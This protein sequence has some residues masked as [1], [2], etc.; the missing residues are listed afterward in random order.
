MDDLSAKGVLEIETILRNA[1]EV[2]RDIALLR[3][4]LNET[5]AAGDRLER[6]SRAV[7]AGLEKVGK[8]ATA[9]AAGLKTANAAWDKQDK[10]Y[11]DYLRHQERATSATA[12][13]AG[14][15]D[16]QTSSLIAQRYALYDVASTYGILSAALLASSGYALKVGADFESAFTDVE[17]T[18]EGSIDQIEGLRDALID[19]STQI[20][21]SFQELS[22]IASLGNQ[23]GIEAENIESFTGTIARFAAISGVSAEQVAESFGKLSNLTGLDPSQYEN[24]GS[25]IAFV[26]RSSAAT[27]ASILSTSKEIAALSTGAGFSAEAIVGLSGALAS[28]SIAPEKAR[29]A[30]S[31]YFSTLESSV[32]AGGESLANFATVV[33][34]TSEEL[35]RMVRNGQGQ[36]VFQG[37][38]RGLSELDNVAKTT[39]LD[40]LGLSAVRVDQTF[41]ALSAN[42]TLVSE[43]FAQSSSAMGEGTELARQYA[44]VVDDLNSRWMMFVNSINA[45]VEAL[46][47]GAVTGLADLLGVMTEVVNA[48]R[49]FADN[50][51]ARHLATMAGILVTTVGLFFAYRAAVTLATAS[52]FALTTA[53]AGL[54]STGTVGGIRGLITAMLGLRSASAG[55]ATTTAAAATASATAGASANTASVGVN[56]LKTALLGLGKATIILALLQ[57]GVSLLTDFRGS[58]IAA[59]DGLYGF[60]SAAA[61]VSAAVRNLWQ[62]FANFLGPLGGLI[63]G[64]VDTAEGLDKNILNGI[65]GLQGWAQSLPTSETDGF[66]GAVDDLNFSTADAAGSLGDFSGGLDDAGGSAASAAEKVRTL[67]DYGNDLS[68]VFTRAFEIRFSGGQGLDAI[69]GGWNSI[70]QAIA[71][72]NQEIEDYRATMM[73]L[74]SDRAI[75]EY[76]LSVA[77]NYGDALRAGELRAELASID[78]DLKKTTADLT[79]AQDKNSK[80]LTGNTAGAIENR[81]EI[82]GLVTNYQSYIQALASSGLSQDQLK[83][84]TA[85]LKADFIAQ[86]TQLGYNEIELQQYAAAFDDVTLA[87]NRVPKN[88]TVTAN[89]DPAMQAL[90]EYEARLRQIGSTN[91]GGGSI[92]AP[93][94]GNAAEIIEA[95]AKIDY[96]AAAMNHFST[97]RPVPMSALDNTNSNL[98]A[99]KARLIALRGYAT[100]GYTGDGGKYEPKGIVH[101]GEFVFSKKATQNIGVANLAYAHNMAKRGY[102]DGGAVAP[103][104]ASS[105]GGIMQLSPVDRQLL[106]DVK[107]A[108]DRKPVL[109]SSDIGSATSARNV[110]ATT[111]RSA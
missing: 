65:R 101:G 89:T 18:S 93:N 37:F 96:Y 91:Y 33:G 83:A 70:R 11:N 17:R 10:I 16:R 30:L 38:L 55:A 29:G 94:T 6:K 7:E 88:V 78:Q 67:V 4:G 104:L 23:L 20:P 22:K 108:I 80:S 90:N 57:A 102:S 98:S 58:M 40:N 62:G 42:T 5:S 52:T 72:T 32:A 48:A 41:K 66:T 27:E 86:A 64:I 53:Q 99:W 85:Q 43:S 73:S 82:L 44:L 97:M 100:G 26:A 14:A 71:D 103:S 47:G 8:S 95:M 105:G 109:S 111:R 50:P 19:M 36:E 24:L 49:E 15:T 21:L 81:A 25:A 46:S 110:N 92:A 60:V 13:A 74:T 45:L 34:V 3:E 31:I 76:W 1:R 75:K 28:L 84:K 54:A 69:N 39:A 2:T 12:N 107:E 35:D 61:A 87:I 68:E 77:E 59:T 51:V 56:R 106:I 79:K 9:S 63:S